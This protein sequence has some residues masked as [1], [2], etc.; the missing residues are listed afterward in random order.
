MA[1]TKDDRDAGGLAKLQEFL[2]DSGRLVVDQAVN[3]REGVQRRLLEVGRGLEEQ[4][5]GLLVATEERLSAQIDDVLNRVA[6]TFRRD[7]DRT[8]ERIRG[9]EHRLADVPREG[10]GELISPVQTIASGAA[11]RASAALARIEE[12]GLR[13]QHL[14]RRV[15]EMTR[16]TTQETIDVGEVRQRLQRIEQRVTDLGRDVGTKLGELSA[17]RERLTRF[18]TRVVDA[19]KEQIARAGETAGL[20]DRFARLEARLSDVSKEQ[21]ARAVE[22][23]GI[24]ERV[25]RVEQRT[26]IGADG[27]PPPAP[28]HLPLGAATGGDD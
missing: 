1:R 12:L 24:R 11:E 22:T 21:L 15:S 13:L 14:E 19:S 4:L 16:E 18:E 17:L 9:L 28:S 26:G 25:F 7:L 27:V 23:A 8:R 3:L 2:T 20:R 6:V 10:L 5:S